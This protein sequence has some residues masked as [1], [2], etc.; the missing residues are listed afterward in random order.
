M[1]YRHL[2]IQILCNHQG[3]WNAKEKFKL[4]ENLS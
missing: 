4:A 2:E 3:R 1:Y